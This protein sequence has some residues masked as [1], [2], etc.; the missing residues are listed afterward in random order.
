VL[1]SDQAGFVHLSR[2]VE[3]RTVRSAFV[4]AIGVGASPAGFPG[5]RIA[6]ANP[7]PGFDRRALARLLRQ[8]QST[9]KAIPGP[10][11]A[12][13]LSLPETFPGLSADEQKVADAARR[14]TIT[15]LDT[16]VAQPVKILAQ[17]R[18]L[19]LSPTT[20]WRNRCS[21]RLRSSGSSRRTRTGSGARS[22]PRTSRCTSSIV[23]N[24]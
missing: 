7:V 21:T 22:T 4:I 1:G 6:A 13:R 19:Q 14:D 11:L 8:A 2:L 18:T 15:V 23:G 3:Y 16:L 9:T 12:R 17:R 24:C 10:K 20:R 5:K